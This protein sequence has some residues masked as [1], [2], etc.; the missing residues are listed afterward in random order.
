MANKSCIKTQQQTQFNWLNDH[1][2]VLFFAHQ[3]R[4]INDTKPQASE[5]K[6]AAD[7]GRVAEAKSV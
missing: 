4:S 2:F 6:R 3:V 7:N 1:I 5:Q